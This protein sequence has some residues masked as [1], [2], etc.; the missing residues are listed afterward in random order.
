[1]N[2]RQVL[3][4][5]KHILGLGLRMRWKHEDG[6]RSID[7]SDIKCERQGEN[8]S[9]CIPHFFIAF[10]FYSFLRFFLL[11][12]QLFCFSFGFDTP[13]I[14]LSRFRFDDCYE[15]IIFD[16]IAISFR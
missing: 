16:E 3:C 6:Y 14:V 11:L 10:D 2:V 12:L 4:V 13:F 8:H 9:S 7:V 15:Q 1:M 5:V